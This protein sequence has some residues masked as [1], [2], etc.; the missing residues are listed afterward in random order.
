LGDNRPEQTVHDGVFA[1]EKPVCVEL[2]PMAEPAQRWQ[3]PGYPLPRPN[4]MFITHL[5]ATAEQVP[6]TRSLRRATP[7][8]AHTAY[9]ANQYPVQ[10]AGVRARQTV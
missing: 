9:R 4:P 2:V 7:L 3:N 5:I 10:G 8:D 6:Q 1:D